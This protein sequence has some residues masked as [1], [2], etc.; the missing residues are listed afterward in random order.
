MKMFTA[1]PEW[2]NG[3]LDHPIKFALTAREK[4]NI[5]E[6]EMRKQPQVEIKIKHHFSYGIY[7]REMF[8]PKG[9]ILTG[10]IHKT[11]QMS[12]ILQGDL[13]VLIDDKI[14]KVK[15]G[16]MWVAPAGTKRIMHANE[17]TR[18]VVIHG[19]H[20]RDLEKIEERFIAQNEQEYIEYCGQM[21]LLGPL[22]I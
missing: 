6:A 11:E 7:G 8:V 2:M 17:D 10:K 21:K 19:T 18:Y 22:S 12:I 20:E 1:K 9:V 15:T 3:L 14:V 5:L 13:S 16:D 4:V